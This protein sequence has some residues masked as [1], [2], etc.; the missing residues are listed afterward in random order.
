MKQKPISKNSQHKKGWW[1]SSSGR[2]PAQ[3]MPGPGSN[4]QY[5][6]K[7]KKKKTKNKPNIF[8]PNLKRLKE[9]IMI[10]I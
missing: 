7:K 1:H 3:Q 2:V 6:Q 9:E 4:P 10:E 8:V 5:W